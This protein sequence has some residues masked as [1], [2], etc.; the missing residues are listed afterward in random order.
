LKRLSVAAISVS[1]LAGEVSIVA[2]DMVQYR[3]K[4]VVISIVT[5]TC[6]QKA[7]SS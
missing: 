4:V 5:A 1:Y 6:L 2:E 3:S 7:S